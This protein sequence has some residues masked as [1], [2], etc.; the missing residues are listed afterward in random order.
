[1]RFGREVKRLGLGG[2]RVMR[3]DEEERGL[4]VSKV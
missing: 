4:G 3:R 1:M 2:V